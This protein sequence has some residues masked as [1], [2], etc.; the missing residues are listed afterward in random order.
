[1]PF[2]NLALL[3]HMVHLSP[4]YDAVVPRWQDE[5]EPLH[6][7]YSRNCIAAIES[8]LRQATGALSSFTRT[9][10]CVTWSRKRSFRFDPEGLS[11]FNINSPDDWIRAQELVARTG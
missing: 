9:S 8:V 5:F 3:R 1:M 4:G 10:S 6:A 11:F 2:L 7:I